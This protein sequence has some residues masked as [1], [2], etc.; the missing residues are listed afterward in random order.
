MEETLTQ[1]QRLVL[2]CLY[3]YL[4]RMNSDLEFETQQSNLFT[5]DFRSDGSIPNN[6]NIP[7]P[8]L[9]GELCDK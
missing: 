8:I 9:F 6:V 5:K 2:I 4:A 7:L 1:F 3:R